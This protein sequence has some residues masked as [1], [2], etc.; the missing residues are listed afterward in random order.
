MGGNDDAVLN[1]LDPRQLVS[2]TRYTT[3]RNT[4]TK[5]TRLDAPATTSVSKRAAERPA[6]EGGHRSRQPEPDQP[7]DTHRRSLPVCEE[8][9]ERSED[10]ARD[11]RHDVEQRAAHV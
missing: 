3:N 11:E 10:R 1:E 2:E 9:G 4:P 7:R 5:A 8:P 6:A